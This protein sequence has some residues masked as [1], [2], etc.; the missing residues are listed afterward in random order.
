MTKVAEYQ[1]LYDRAHAAG[2]AA[3]EAAKAVPMIVGTPV[4]MLDSLM[5]GDGGGFDQTKP[6]YYVEGG[7]CGFAAIVLPGT[8]GF[9]RWAKKT[10]KVTAHYGGGMAFRVRAGGQSLQRKEAYAGAFAG[11][12]REAGIEKVHVWSRMD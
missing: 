5:G 2:V 7:V 8:T 1:A 6:T 4:N 11:V 12:L 3:L 9:A 10:G